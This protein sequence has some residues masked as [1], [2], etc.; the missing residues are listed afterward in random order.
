MMLRDWRGKE[1]VWRCSETD[2]L[3]RSWKSQAMRSWE[4]VWVE[5]GVI[6]VGCADIVVGLWVELGVP[7]LRV[8]H[9]MR[10]RKWKMWEAYAEASVLLWGS[11]WLGRCLMSRELVGGSLLVAACWCDLSV[12][13]CC[14]PYVGASLLVG[15]CWWQLVGGSL[16]VRSVGGS[17]LLAVCWWEFV[18]GS[19]CGLG[20]L[21]WPGAR[22]GNRDGVR[23][24]LGVCMVVCDVKE[25]GMV[26]K[27]PGGEKT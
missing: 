12:A 27:L 24:D 18:G 5:L 6:E 15:V 9:M 17:L 10:R 19:L 4:G 26:R 25:V 14:W 3:R 7:V 1:I 22:D 11:G 21:G 23:V 2:K 13:I 20:C 8:Q 16:L